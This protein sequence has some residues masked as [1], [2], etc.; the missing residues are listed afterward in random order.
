MRPSPRL[1][2]PPTDRSADAELLAQL[3]AGDESA[4]ELL[5]REHYERLCRMAASMLGSPMAAE[6]LVQ[7]LL[8]HLS[9]HRADLQVR[10]TLGGYLVT[11]VR[12]RVLNAIRR[13]QLESRWSSTAQATGGVLNLHARQA[14]T[15]DALVA[16]DLELAIARAL[17]ELPPRCRQAFIL[18]RQQDLSYAEIACIMHISPKTGGG[19]CRGRCRGTSCIS[20]HFAAVAAQL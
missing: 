14:A 9:E 4:F 2:V 11:A 19:R 18:R 7:D 15:D 5:F 1:M 16:R 10:D 6:E 3:R 8:L 20:R 13:R 17:D 12:N